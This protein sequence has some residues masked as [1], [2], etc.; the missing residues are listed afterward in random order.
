MS[1][2]QRIHDPRMLEE[3]AKER[4]VEPV[5]IREYIDSFRY[6]AYPHGGGSIGLER[7][8]MQYCGLQNVRNCSLFPRDSQRLTP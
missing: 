7:L 8:L 2:G 6:G 1:G 4:D 5:N 3:R